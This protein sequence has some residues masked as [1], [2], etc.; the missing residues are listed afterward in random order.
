MFL[1]CSFGKKKTQI[2]YLKQIWGAQSSSQKTSGRKR[3]LM[4]LIIS[5]SSI[6]LSLPSL[7]IEHFIFSWHISLPWGQKLHFSALFAIGHGIVATFCPRQCKRMCCVRPMRF[8][9][10][11]E[12]LPFFPSFKHCAGC[13][14]ELMAGILVIVLDHVAESMWRDNGRTR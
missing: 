3:V 1:L 9:L 4:T 6:S 8:F 11:K 13:N 10:K 14:A 2:V 12:P 7:V 5:C